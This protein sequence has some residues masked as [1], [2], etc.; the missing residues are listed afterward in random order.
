MKTLNLSDV[1]G[2]VARG[3]TFPY[4]R[5]VFAKIGDPKA[6]QA[7]VGRIADHVTTGEKWATAS[8]LPP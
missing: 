4:A 2:F 1:Q 6:A 7:F 5:F 3:Y 8:L